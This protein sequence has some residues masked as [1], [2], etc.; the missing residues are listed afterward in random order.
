MSAIPSSDS[1][2]NNVSIAC[3]IVRLPHLR[4]VEFIGTPTPAGL[5]ALA[6][7]PHLTHLTAHDLQS[8]DGLLTLPALSHLTMIDARP[9]AI[10]AARTAT[11]LQVTI[12]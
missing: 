10:G 11:H 2:R 6:A 4:R 5:K 7:L 8:V 12:R 1:S 3:P 9:D